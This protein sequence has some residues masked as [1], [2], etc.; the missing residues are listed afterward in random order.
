V[1]ILV[2]VVVIVEIQFV[3]ARIQHRQSGVEFG[4]GAGSQHIEDERLAGLRV[5]AEDIVIACFH[6]AVHECRQVEGLGVRGVV[7]RLPFAQCG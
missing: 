2:D 5:K 7:V 6:G 4:A 1:R 3:G